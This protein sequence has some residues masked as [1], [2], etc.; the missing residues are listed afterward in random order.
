MYVDEAATIDKMVLYYISHRR[1]RTSVSCNT[2]TSGD[3]RILEMYLHLPR[4]N[5]L[6]FIRVSPTALHLRRNNR[7]SVWASLVGHDVKSPCKPV[8]F[9]GCKSGA[10][11]PI[12]VQTLDNPTRPP[13]P[14]QFE[15]QITS[16]SSIVGLSR[17]GISVKFRPKHIYDFLLTGRGYEPAVHVKY[18]VPTLLDLNTCMLSLWPSK[19]RHEVF[20][21]D[22]YISFLNIG[23]SLIL[24]VWL[25]A[26]GQSCGGISGCLRG[27]NLVSFVP[28]SFRTKR[29]AEEWAILRL[30]PTLTKDST[31]ESGYD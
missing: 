5:F 1:D 9:T 13:A 4:W 30:R 2:S 11:L 12:E 8:P 6:G 19:T 23:Q 16:N 26:D 24:P 14:L 3:I 27:R 21:G 18:F 7:G 31:T 17:M 29:R 28:D 15:L 22:A 10:S 20:L 25:N